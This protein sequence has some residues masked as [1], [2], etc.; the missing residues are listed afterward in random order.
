MQVWDERNGCV[1]EVSDADAFAGMVA[2]ARSLGEP[3]PAAGEAMRQALAF[4]RERGLVSASAYS[5]AGVGPA[6]VVTVTSGSSSRRYVV[7]REDEDL[8]AA[9]PDGPVRR[10]HHFDGPQFDF[11]GQWLRGYGKVDESYRSLAGYQIT[12]VVRIDRVKVWGDRA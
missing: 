3:S 12:R 4:G 5:R 11:G 10:E 8:F 6:I 9:I 1:V 2:Y 7:V